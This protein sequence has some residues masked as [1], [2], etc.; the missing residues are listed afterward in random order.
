[1]LSIIVPTRSRPQ[2]LEKKLRALEAPAPPFEVLVIV[3]DPNDASWAFLAEYRPPYPLR[4]FQGPGQGPAAARNLG[5]SMARG[6][7][8]LFSDDDVIPQPGWVAA[9]VA[10]HQASLP[11]VGIGRLR[12]PD[13]LKGSGAAELLGPKAFWWHATGNNTSLP[14]ALFEQVGGYDALQFS[15]YGGEDPDLGYRLWKAGA[16]FRFL[17]QAEAIH[18]AWDHQQGALERAHKAGAAHVRVYQKH[19]DPRIAWA[20]GIHPTLLRFK[21]L[22]LPYL[23]SPRGAYEL[24]Y[25]QGAWQAYIMSSVSR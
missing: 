20:L 9:H 4:A 21:L 17:P 18:E 6:S 2:L 5:A 13:S 23:R 15:G 14:R 24:A 11:L 8:L 1:M 16:R 19:R 12:L 22:L 3:D 25:A 7:V 10:V